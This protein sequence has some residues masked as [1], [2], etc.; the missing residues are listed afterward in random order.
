MIRADLP[1]R[2]ETLDALIWEGPDDDLRQ[3]EAVL[4]A[5]GGGT[6]LAAVLRELSDESLAVAIRKGFLLKPAFEE[7]FVHRYTPYLARWFYRWGSDV[8]AAQD[9]TQQLFLRFFQRRLGSFQAGDSFRAY[10]WKAAYHLWV[11]KVHRAS[12]PHSLHHVPEPP[13]GGGGPVGEAVAREMEERI[14]AALRRLPADQ[15]RVLRETMKGRKADEI[16]A[17]MGLS[18]RAVFMHLFRARRRMEQ[19]LA[20]TARTISKG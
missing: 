15:Q 12:R 1:D 5:P 7:L 11:E 8:H 16:A 19:A 3:R 18:K 4:S 17:E 6:S 20:V 14:E 9:L 13:A 10:L 2:A